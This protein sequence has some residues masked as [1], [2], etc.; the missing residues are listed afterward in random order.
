M[1][2]L[3]IYVHIPYCTVKCGYCDFNAYAGLGST[4]GDYAQALLTEVGT[5][6]ALLGER[7]ISS[8]GFGGGTPGEFPASDIAAVIEA[9]RGRAVVPALAD[10]LEITLEANP[11]TTSGPA[12]VALRRAGVTRISFGAQ[13][14]IAAELQFLDRLHS[15]E[16][17]LA[18]V[19]GARAAGFEDVSLDLI[20]GL[21]GQS[22]AEWEYSLRQAISAAPDHISTYALTVEDGTPLAGRVAR[23]EVTPIDPDIAAD[24]YERTTDLLAE[25]GFGQYELSNWALPG[26]ESRHNQAYWRWR[27]YLGIGAGAHGFE[28]GT[29]WE[30]IAHP[31]AY[32]AALKDRPGE[33]PIANSYVP[34]RATAM[35]DWLTTSLRLTE[36]FEP[37][38]FAAEFGVP[39]SDALGAVVVRAVEAGVLEQLSNGRI[40]LTRRGRLLHGELSAL[41]LEALSS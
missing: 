28:G 17:N 11:G 35:F 3:A 5:Y 41:F 22:L 29:R 8:I 4:M 1:K 25:A 18:A 14:F 6:G 10:S 21:P 26:H 31:R 33:R 15:P 40:A 20:Y 7:E 27:D 24:M 38:G 34:D 12:L 2:P 39:L 23:G 30:N 16:A 36:G 9:L 13:S 19:V 32:I 37:A